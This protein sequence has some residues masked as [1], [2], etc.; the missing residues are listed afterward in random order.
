M[1]YAVCVLVFN[2]LAVVVLCGWR[3]S[4]DQSEDLE[5]TVLQCGQIK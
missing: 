5:I 4:F 3:K 2:L 1:L